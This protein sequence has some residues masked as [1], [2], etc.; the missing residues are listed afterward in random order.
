MRNGKPWA[1]CGEFVVSKPSRSL[2]LTLNAPYA[3][4]TGDT[5]IV[6]R[7]TYKQPGAGTTVLRPTRHA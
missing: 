7:K 3:L 2:T 1:P 6:T 5:W 4:K